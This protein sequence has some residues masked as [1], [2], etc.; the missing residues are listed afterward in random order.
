MYFAILA[1]HAEGIVPSW[2]EE[3]DAA[4]MTELLRIND[5]L[6]EEKSLGPRGAPRPHVGGRDAPRQGRRNGD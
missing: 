4:L 2:S 3:E 1:Y 5:R 6:V